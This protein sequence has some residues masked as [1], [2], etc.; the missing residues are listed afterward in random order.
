MLARYLENCK[1]ICFG[2]F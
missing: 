1:P 2:I